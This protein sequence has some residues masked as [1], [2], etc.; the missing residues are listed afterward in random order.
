MNALKPATFEFVRE[1]TL[2]PDESRK[3]SRNNFRKVLTPAAQLL[4]YFNVAWI[5]LADYLNH[6]DDFIGIDQQV[7]FQPGNFVELIAEGQA[8]DPYRQRLL[9]PWIV[10]YLERIDNNALNLLRLDQ[11]QAAIY[12][13]MSVLLLFVVQ[14]MLTTFGYSRA[15]GMVGS[16]FVAALLPIAMRDHGYQAWSWLEAV[17]F[18]LTIIMTLRKSRLTLFALLGILAA[19]NRETA[20][21]LPLIPL[22]IAWN[23][24]KFGD[25]RS[26]LKMVGVLAVSAL[27]TRFF[28]MFVWPK[29]S[30]ERT[31]TIDEIWKWNT[32]PEYVALATSRLIPFL[33]IVIVMVLI[34]MVLKRYPSD[35]LWIPIFS[36]PPIIVAW[37]FFALWFEVR[38]LLPVV[39]LLLP[40]VLSALFEP[41]GRRQFQRLR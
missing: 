33:G 41:V 35:A 24:R 14:S 22:A 15:A 19:L 1:T 11:I 37:G 2:V 7:W 5:L 30:P 8:E 32:T 18:P 25:S 28:L 3:N 6:L 10:I 21:I 9:V 38:V 12:L 13:L 4:V 40:L 39:I 34:A 31:L 23:H 20:I 17:I 36:I 26:Y 27:S 16:P 29:S